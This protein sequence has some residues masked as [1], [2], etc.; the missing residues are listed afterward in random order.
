MTKRKREWLWARLGDRG[1]YER[2]DGMYDLGDSLEELEVFGPFERYGKYGI[3][4]PDFVGPYN[5][6]SLFWGDD[7]VQPTTEVEDSVI[8]YL[9]ERLAPKENIAGEVDPGAARELDLFIRNDGDLYRQQHIP[10]TKNLITKMAR[11]TYDSEKAVKMFMY[12]AESGAKKYKKEFGDELKWHE[13]FNVATRR[14]VAKSLR[15]SFE[16]EA[17]LGNYDH[18]LPKKYQR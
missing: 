9:N 12:L 8:D 17:E 16:T 6:I 15:N 11:G 1:D 13:M 4:S 10:I 2:Y 18:L 3:G 14:E 7:E 5:Y